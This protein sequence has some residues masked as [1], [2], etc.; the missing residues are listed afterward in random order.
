MKSIVSLKIAVRSS[1]W[2]D[3]AGRPT[4]WLNLDDSDVE[5]VALVRLRRFA[6]RRVLELTLAGVDVRFGPLGAIV[7][8]TTGNDSF[9]LVWVHT[10]LISFSTFFYALE[11]HV[12]RLTVVVSGPAEHL[13]LNACLHEAL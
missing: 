8:N 13:S 6:Q 11:R 7:L 3:C 2:Q 4:C 10:D 9:E 5:Y 12:S 1:V